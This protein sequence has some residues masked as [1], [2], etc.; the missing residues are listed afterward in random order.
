MQSTE[1]KTLD[2]LKMQAGNVIEY[3]LNE[4]DF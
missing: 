3:G 2:T 1:M 4:Y